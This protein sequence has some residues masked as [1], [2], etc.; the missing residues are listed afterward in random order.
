MAN[1]RDQELLLDRLCRA[2]PKWEPSPYFA[3]RVRNRIQQ[4]Q[5]GRTL[6]GTIALMAHRLVPMMTAASLCFLLGVVLLTQSLDL[7][8]DEDVRLSDLLPSELETQ[9][10][11]LEDLVA[12]AVPPNENYANPTN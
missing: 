9:T 7:A 8:P 6:P 1:E 4:L 10:I 11:T 5:G 2:V 12:S 3:V